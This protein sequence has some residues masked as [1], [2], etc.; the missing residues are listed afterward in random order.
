MGGYG[1]RAPY[2]SGHDGEN[3]GR[4]SAAETNGMYHAERSD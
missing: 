3:A 1:A 2:V 4:N